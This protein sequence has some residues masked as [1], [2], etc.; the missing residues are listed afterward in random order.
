MHRFRLRRHFPTTAALVW[1]P[2]VIIVPSLQGAEL[3]GTWWTE[4]AE[5]SRHTSFAAAFDGA[6]LSADFA[7]G[8]PQSGGFGV[9]PSVP[10]K[11]GSAV[12]LVEDGGHLHY[13]GESNVNLRRGTLR[14]DVRGDVWLDETSRWLCE[15][16]GGIRL[17]VRRSPHTLSL[18][19]GE[20]MK[21]TTLSVVELPI[22]AVAPGE[23]HTVVASWDRDDGKGWITLDGRWV[24]G[25]LAWPAD[26]E[27]AL[28]LYVGG[29]YNATRGGTNH[30]GME[31]DNLVIYDRTLPELEAGPVVLPEADRDLL[32][33]AEDGARLTLA[34]L[35]NLQR[36]G[37]W[38]NVY[39][40]P[41]LIGA[42]A[43]QRERVNLD[44]I[45]Q[46]DKSVG[47]PYTAARFLYAYEILGDERFLATALRTAEFYLAAQGGD[48]GWIHQYRMS[49]GGMVPHADVNKPKFQ[50]SVQSN[51]IYFLVYA[52]RITGDGRYLD[53]A[54][55]AG[56]FYL[57]G[58]NP[59]GSWSHHWDRR[60]GIGR[61][62]T[63]LPQ[64]GELNDEC[65]NDAIDVMVLLYHLT[66]DVRY[67]E[68]V[69]RAGEWLIDAQLTGATVGWADQYDDRNEPV[70]ARSFEPPSW[71][72]SATVAATRALVELYRLSGDDRYLRPVRQ[73][74]AWLTERYPDGAGWYSLDP[75]T[76][77]PIAAWE[78]KVY[79]L[80][81][82]AG[83]EF[84]RTRPTLTGYY[85]SVRTADTIRELLAEAERRDHSGSR[86]TLDAATERLPRLR[87]AAREALKTQ[88]EAGVWVRSR[89]GEFIGSIG[90]G[91]SSLPVDLLHLLRY[92]E[93]VRME[94][95]ELPPVARGDGNIRRMAGLAVDWY[96][97]PWRT[98]DG[99]T[100]RMLNHGAK[101]SDRS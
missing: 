72:H 10:G 78:R 46:N 75:Q 76:G 64:G 32:H 82:P 39:T 85:S 50:D 54:R 83:L 53:A 51:P 98:P 56:E 80:D 15:L 27:P 41:T 9:Q 97:V 38:T 70:W 59:N 7:R 37:G 60:A 8:A 95:G 12:R 6:D 93:T 29:G 77:R 33:R 58:Q 96:D 22:D 61:T 91:F 43:S 92:I 55:R 48:G 26:R 25:D 23:W 89:Y 88:N 3:H 86:S 57:A 17:G 87:E 21:D 100:V 30:P 34:T 5:R 52:H 2:L 71:D 19:L 28:V 14:F 101:R 47:T 16:R 20:V 44:E 24:E 65:M 42:L 90:A 11:H 62:A 45:I 31:I 1:L 49:V 13:R 73:C 66:A 84:I 40:W 4:P 67:L 79:F 99:V 36:W 18:V 68:A 35:A 69:R 94:G 81:E 63:G 74:L